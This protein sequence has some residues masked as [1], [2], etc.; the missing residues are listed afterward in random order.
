MTQMLLRYRW[1]Y[2]NPVR[3]MNCTTRYHATEEE[4]RQRHPDAVP[5][6]GSEEV[7]ILAEN[8]LANSMSRF[9]LIT[10]K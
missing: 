7:L 9:Q 6:P 1:C 4:M 2:F 10:E 3:N 8:P 5:V